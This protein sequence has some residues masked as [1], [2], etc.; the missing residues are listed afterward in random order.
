MKRESYWLASTKKTGFKML[1]KNMS[2]EVVVVG[3]GI[4]GITT[5]F[6]LQEQGYKVVLI[7]RERCC[8]KVT[9]HTTAKITYYHF[10]YA[11]LLKTLGKKKL[12]QYRESN[13]RAIDVVEE[14]VRKYHIMCDF[15][16]KDLYVYAR[17]EQGFIDLKAEYR[18]LKTAGALIHYQEHIS[19]PG[20]IKGA[21]KIPRQAQFHPRKFLLALLTL[22]V[23][24][25]GIIFENTMV[26]AVKKGE[27]HV[28]KKV[29]KAKKIVIAT[30][31]PVHD[32]PGF[33]FARLSPSTSYA[34]AVR[35]KEKFPEG[36]FVGIEEKENTY[37]IQHD[38]HG[39]LLI[40]GGK[41][42]NSGKNV[43]ATAY[44]ELEK[45]VS[46]LFTVRSVE[47]VW[48]AHDMVP[49]DDIP[50]IG[51]TSPKSNIF[52]TTGFAKW[53]MTKGVLSGLLLRDAIIGKKNKWLWLYSPFRFNT[54]AG[55]ELLRK[56]VCTVDYLVGRRLR[57]YET[58]I[59][60]IKEESG[61][62][63]HHDKKN[64]A[65]Y[66]DKKGGLHGVD[67]YCTHMGCVVGWNGNE[68]TW[69]CPCHGSRFDIEGNVLYGPAQKPLKKYKL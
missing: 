63:V 50:Y 13:E 14:L 41:D 34:I 33:Y 31:Y 56:G 35:I 55:K 2:T 51:E 22:F 28:N 24:K 49:V 67:P 58:K 16:R 42:H 60:K 8:S 40:V 32:K 61:C 52:M 38:T 54:T 5:A 12:I 47:Y 25:G 7:D 10:N 23:R 53:G 9:G 59:E 30:N 19:F 4:A 37:R 69:D 65:V 68:K 15:E 17:T 66:K 36:M 46:Q 26:T 6:L 62:V 48:A 18:A 44:K 20:A 21:F 27:V 11:S 64:I 1:T 43:Q 29:I 45:D 3:A 39:D 57:A